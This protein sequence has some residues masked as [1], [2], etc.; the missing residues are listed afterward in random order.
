MAVL[1]GATASGRQMAQALL[2]TTVATYYTAPAASMNV[3]SP[4]ATAYIKEIILANSSAS[5]AAVTLYVV[6]SGGTVGGAYGN[7]ILPAVTVNNNDTKILS[8]LNL[9]MPAGATIQAVCNTA[10]AI[11]M[12]ISGVEVV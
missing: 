11:N 7:M 5:S 4:S 10:S 12:T 1:S 8:G 6:P 2:T 3:T 9:M